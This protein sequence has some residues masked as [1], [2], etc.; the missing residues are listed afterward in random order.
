MRSTGNSMPKCPE[1]ARA[2]NFM[3]T[4]LP[5]KFIYIN[6]KG[7]GEEVS[8]E[9]WIWGVVYEDNKEIHQFEVT[10]EGRGVFHRVGEVDQSR[11][12]LWVLF[13][14][15]TEKRIDIVLPKGAKI[16]HKYRKYRLDIGTI[17]ERCE[18]VYIFG[19]KYKGKEY[20]NFIMPNDTIIQSDK[21]I[22]LTQFG[23]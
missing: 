1:I 19:Y 17:A 9:K 5:A 13:K 15:G 2:F 21:D 22:Q 23:L 4:K 16:I 3:E 6:E 11:I 12:K 14:P 8:L 18:T 10:P 7:I 20:L